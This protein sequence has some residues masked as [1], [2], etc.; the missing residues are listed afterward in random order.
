MIT[1]V[2][3]EA[4]K[5]G[6][7]PYNALATEVKNKIENAGTGGGGATP[8]WS[9]TEGKE[10][11]ILNRT[12]YKDAPIEESTYEESGLAWNDIREIY[13]FGYKYYKVTINGETQIIDFVGKDWPQY[14]F[15]KEEQNKLEYDLQ[16]DN[17]VGLKVSFF[18]NGGYEQMIV[19]E[20]YPMDSA[21]PETI[22]VS[23]TDYYV[24][25]KQLDEEFIPDTIAR[26]EQLTELHEEIA[27]KADKENIYYFEWEGN[28]EI[29]AD[30]LTEAEIEKI[31]NADKVVLY[32]PQKG[33][34]IYPVGCVVQ[35]SLIA[36]LY[37]VG[38]KMVFVLTIY[39]NEQRYELLPFPFTVVETTPQTLSVSDKKQAR[40]NISAQ[41]KLV[42]GVN[43]ATIN[44]K[45]LLSGKDITIGK[46]EVEITH[47]SYND[48]VDNGITE[49][50]TSTEDIKL[51]DMCFGKYDT[52]ILYNSAYDNSKFMDKR[53][54][55]FVGSRYLYFPNA[56]E[57]GFSYRSYY[58]CGDLM[59][60]AA[61]NLSN[62]EIKYDGSVEI[63]NGNSCHIYI[64]NI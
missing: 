59:L 51:Y 38:H 33:G 27:K 61:C 3:G 37:S 11:H 32:S 35:E 8:D 2:K 63:I 26:A 52:V 41:E 46:N 25:F 44:G 13:P 7:I 15:E 5:E 22:D 55:T 56:D 45:S 58:M 30:Y 29:V 6:S 36:F 64:K 28:E 24:D 23:I 34:L 42:T 50:G 10:G 53:T 4:I 19:V 16:F 21:A 47:R 18:E 17:N 9:A 12:H 31:A 14:D 54:F 49:F 1:K 62:Y 43:L 57:D 48:F 40:E 20:Y 60:I 39:T